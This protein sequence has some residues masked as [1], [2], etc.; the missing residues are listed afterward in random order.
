MN[1]TRE[2]ITDLLPLYFSGEASADTHAM[3][4]E[5]FRQDPEFA[6]L[7]RR[8]SEVRERLVL[9]EVAGPEAAAEKNALKKT[10]EMVQAR[11]AWLGFAIAYTLAPLLFFKHH[12]EWWIMF[13]ENPEAARMFFFFGFFCWVVY[14]FYYTKLRKSGL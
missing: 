13:R 14:L 9:R 8:M 7:A 5:F 12:G 2:V 1:V 3:V 6:H 11:N 10:R 4:E